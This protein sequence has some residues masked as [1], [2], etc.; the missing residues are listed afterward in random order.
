MKKIISMNIVLY[1]SENSAKELE[2]NGNSALYACENV[3]VG[4]FANSFGMRSVA[5]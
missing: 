1:G 5:L 3:E 4:N 2:I